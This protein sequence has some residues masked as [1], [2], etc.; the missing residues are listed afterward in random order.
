MFR[1][2]TKKT[3][4]AMCG[5]GQEG[6]LFAGVGRSRSEA[7]PPLPG[8]GSGGDASRLRIA[9]GR[10]QLGLLLLRQMDVLLLDVAVAA[11]VVRHAGQLHRRRQVVA[12][13][14]AGDL[15]EQLAV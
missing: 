5:R 14:L 2:K 1:C 9:E 13:Q 3:S 12:V 4:P 7:E 11:D 15:V 10:Q 8:D 6:V